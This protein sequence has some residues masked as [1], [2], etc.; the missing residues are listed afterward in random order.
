MGVPLVDSA[1]RRFHVLIVLGALV[2]MVAGFLALMVVCVIAAV[3]GPRDFVAYELAAG[4]GLMAW[5]TFAAAGRE[6]RAVNRG[7]LLLLGGLISSV[8]GQLV[9]N[10]SVS[11]TGDPAWAYPGLGIA[12]IGLALTLLSYVAKRRSARRNAR[13][14]LI[15]QLTRVLRSRSPGSFVSSSERSRLEV[16]CDRFPH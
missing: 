2:M 3:R 12:G 14:A 11:Q 15:A 4:A 9:M 13:R 1:A 16:S 5:G 8:V 10:R 7:E 6:R